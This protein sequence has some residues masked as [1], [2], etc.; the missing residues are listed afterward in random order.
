MNPVILFRRCFD[1]S[2]PDV[3]EEFEVAKKYFNVV[4]TR[5]EVPDDSFVI[6]RYSVLPY[7]S[8]LER[9]LQ[10]HRSQL[11]NSLDNHRY[12]ADICQYVEDLGNLTPAT[13]TTWGHLQGGEWIVKG[14]TNSRKFNW[15]TMMYAK[16]RE[17]LLS[18]IG[19]LLDDPFI[20]EQGIVVRDFVQLERIGTGLHGL[21]INKEWRCFFY[22]DN[23]LASG[24]YWTSH[25]D[26][27]NEPLPL[28]GRRFA[29]D[30]AEIVSKK[31]NFFVMDIAKK[32]DGGYIVIELNDAQM[33]GLSMCN[34]DVLYK[35]LRELL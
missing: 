9:E 17:Q 35:N 10:I 4:E 23:L 18:V 12:V 31:C 7:Y 5:T 28:D 20:S 32:T 34:P 30:V 2:D 19:K 24:F 15:D 11:I 26:T 13:H 16:G 27:F 1:L 6:G 8:E 22:K 29:L 3:Q 14:K 21:P 33:S 25:A